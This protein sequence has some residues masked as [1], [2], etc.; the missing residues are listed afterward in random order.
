[1]LNI[2]WSVLVRGC[3]NG[4]AQ[5]R[6]TT[7]VAFKEDPAWKAVLDTLVPDYQTVAGFFQVEQLL[8]LVLGSRQ[9]ERLLAFDPINT[10]EKATLTF[11]EPGFAHTCPLPLFFTDRGRRDKAFAYSCTLVPGSLQWS[12]PA[13]TVNYT[14]TDG[15]T[16]FLPLSYEKEI[17]L[18]GPFP[19]PLYQFDV[20]YT[21]VLVLELDE[22]MGRLQALTIPWQDT[23]LARVW[24]EDFSWTEQMAALVMAVIEA[25]ANRV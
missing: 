5:C 14:V 16:S 19:E 2:S 7:P 24:R 18:R 11:P 4:L 23:E 1:M 13:Q 3:P 12:T 8:R 21:P 10:Y 15:L 22:L 17:R 20:A 6:R 9:R 25:N